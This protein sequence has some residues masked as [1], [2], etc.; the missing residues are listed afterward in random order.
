MGEGPA[1]WDQLEAPQETLCRPPVECRPFEN[2]GLRRG[3]LGGSQVCDAWCTMTGCI[4]LIGEENR[5]E[6]RSTTSRLWFSPCAC[7][8][9]TPQTST[10]GWSRKMLQRRTMKT[11]CKVMGASALW[12]PGM[13]QGIRTSRSFRDPE[14][15][16]CQDA[17]PGC[18]P[19]WHSSSSAVRWSWLGPWRNQSREI[20]WTQEWEG[21]RHRNRFLLV[22]S[23]TSQIVF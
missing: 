3:L 5:W 6:A 20:P 18:C 9:R 17:S 2:S 11:L 14:G 10:L 21:L 7:V 1:H 22:P 16:S 19:P 13:T 15:V 23:G 12:Q 8:S 4:R